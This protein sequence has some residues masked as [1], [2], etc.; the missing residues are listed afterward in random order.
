VTQRVASGPAILTVK[1]A[2][3]LSHFLKW[4]FDYY[5]YGSLISVT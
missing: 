2:G 5:F 3:L 4:K 1:D